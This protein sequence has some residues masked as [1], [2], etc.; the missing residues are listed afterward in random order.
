MGPAENPPRILVASA[1]DRDGN[2]LLVNYRTI[3][4]GF[5]GESY[6]N[7][8][9]SKVALKDVR[10]LTVKGEELTI[11]AARK[12]IADRDTPILVSPYKSALASFYQG[13]FTP[14]TLHFVFPA[15]APVW[16]TIQDPGGP[17][18]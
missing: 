13:M 4:I 2:L 11:E 16:K 7:R 12:R 18:R 10:I 5:K 8:S 9:L 17:V 15:K 3:Y 6:N 14:E 1:I